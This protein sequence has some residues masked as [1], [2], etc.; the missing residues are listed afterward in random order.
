MSS[1]NQSTGKAT[2]FAKDSPFDDVAMS[3]AG[4]P[5]GVSAVL[6]EVRVDP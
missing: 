2:A 1:P 4:A 3:P 6:V 5:Q